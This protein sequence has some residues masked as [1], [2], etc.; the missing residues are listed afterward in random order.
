LK[1]RDKLNYPESSIYLLS[2]VK[3]MA[4]NDTNNTEIEL[5][6][7]FKSGDKIAFTKVVEQFTPTLFRQARAI[8]GCKQEAEEVCQDVFFKAFNKRQTLKK[9]RLLPWLSQINHFHCLDILR[10]RKRRPQTV[11]E[12]NLLHKMFVNVDFEMKEELP[13][14]LLQYSENERFLLVLRCVDKLTYKEIAQITGLTEGTLRN[15]FSKLVKAIR[16]KWE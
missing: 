4:L 16:E 1:A 12:E 2:L 9:N 15:L 7:K 13:E 5:I 14:F 3:K 8:L 11:S 10:K 6:Q